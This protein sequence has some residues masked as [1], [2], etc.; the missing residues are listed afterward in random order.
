MKE[1]IIIVK[2]LNMKLIQKKYNNRNELFIIYSQ[3]DIVGI[4]FKQPIGMIGAIFL[5]N[6]I[7][8]TN[9]SQVF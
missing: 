7:R 2:I 3:R 8:F 1:D 6:N 5:N 9:I 4:D